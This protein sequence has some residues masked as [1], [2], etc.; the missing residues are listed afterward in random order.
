[1]DARRRLTDC[2]PRGTHVA[3]A[4]DALVW[5]IFGHLV[6]AS[7]RAI[8]ATEALVIQMLDDTCDRV[9]LIRIDRARDHASWLK[10]VVTRGRHV[11]HDWSCARAAD[12]QANITPRFVVVQ[13]IERV[14]G[15]DTSLA[16]GAAVQIYLKGVLLA[17]PWRRGG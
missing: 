4:D 7:H 3:L 15:D 5:M 16:T 11:L 2:K 8:L 17:G 1:M 13:P 14:T 6:R 12:Q 9:F 10:A